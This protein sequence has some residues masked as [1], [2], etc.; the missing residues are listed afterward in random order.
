MYRGGLVSASVDSNKNISIGVRTFSDF[1]PI[2]ISRGQVFRAGPARLP[3]TVWHESFTSHPRE[4]FT[5]CEHFFFEHIRVNYGY[6]QYRAIQQRRKTSEFG[7]PYGSPLGFPFVMSQ[8]QINLRHSQH[9]LQNWY[10]AK[11]V[12]RAGATLF[13]MGRS[14]PCTRSLHSHLAALCK[15]PFT[16]LMHNCNTPSQQ[17]RTTTCRS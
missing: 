8:P 10:A 7:S 1:S 15:N 17:E 12:K 5:F 2:S 11:Y 6:R 13:M 3:K 9:E 14:R 16:A 4:S